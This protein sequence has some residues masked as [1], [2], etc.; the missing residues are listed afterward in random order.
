MSLKAISLFTG[1][2]GL[3]TGFIKEHFD[4]V[5]S[6]EYDKHAAE[7]YRINHPST[8][9]IEGDIEE[10]LPEIVEFVSDKEIDLVLGGPS[11]Q[12]FSVAGKMDHNDPRNKMVWKF[13]EVVEKVKPKMFVMENVKA[14]A[15]LDRWEP[16]RRE[17]F[18][19]CNDLGYSVFPILLNSKDFG[20]PQK[21]ER[22]FFIG[23]KNGFY[24]EEIWRNLFI[25]EQREEVTVIESIRKFGPAGT[26]VNPLNATAKISLAVNPIFR[27][28]PYAG[29][30]FNGAGRPIDVFS[31]SNTLPASM[32]GNR[33]PIIDEEVLYG[34]ENISFVE[35]YHKLLKEQPDIDKT[36][37]V[38]PSS[39]RRLTIT[40][41]A[42][43]QTFPSDYI[44][45]G[46][47]SAVYRQIGNAVPCELASAVARVIKKVL[48]G[49][50]QVFDTEQLMLNLSV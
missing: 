36:T 35:R 33:T 49:N 15:S 41:A 40:E 7:T 18:S 8:K 19:L 44:F 26:K 32:G 45:S 24:S 4:I 50:V 25:N 13:F 31:Q 28:S 42:A 43:I 22:V 21:R 30:L 34:D 14:L 39:L 12:G 1:A 38:L 48:N 2:G 6:N 20:V 5:V 11:C 37:I 10:K 3:D 47:M 29:M 27:K 23:V 46:P 17:I 9:M 16:I